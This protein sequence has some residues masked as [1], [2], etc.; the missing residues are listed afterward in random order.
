M[1]AESL[2]TAFTRDR[3]L[4]LSWARLIQSMPHISFFADD[5]FLVSAY[6]NN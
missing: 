3:N 2:L 1:K 4:F 6:L 5:L